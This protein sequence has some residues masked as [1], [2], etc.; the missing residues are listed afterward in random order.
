MV[1]ILYKQNAIWL[2]YYKQT[3]NVRYGCYIIYTN[4]KCDMVAILNQPNTKRDMVAILLCKQTENTICLLY[5]I[6]QHRTQYGCNII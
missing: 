5:D 3:Q 4:T 2:L 6:N 1:A